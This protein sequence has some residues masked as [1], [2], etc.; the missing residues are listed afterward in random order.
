MFFVN[1]VAILLFLYET[2]AQ[3]SN[4][5]MIK[6]AKQKGIFDVRV[7]SLYRNIGNDKLLPLSSPNFVQIRGN[8]TTDIGMAQISYI[9]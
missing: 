9:Q 7:R 4:N 3:W 6:L 2:I 5:M 8:D 1:S